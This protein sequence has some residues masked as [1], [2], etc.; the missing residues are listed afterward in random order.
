MIFFSTLH[1]KKLFIDLSRE[2]LSSFHSTDVQAYAIMPKC[3]PSGPVELSKLWCYWL[4]SIDGGNFILLPHDNTL[5]LQK[6]L[7]WSCLL[8]WWP[9]RQRYDK[10][11]LKSISAQ[12]YITMQWSKLHFRLDAPTKIGILKG[13]KAKYG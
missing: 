5:V 4:K 12:Q 2:H 1:L 10:K 9:W 8:E 7:R 11:R 6:E 13:L 3:R